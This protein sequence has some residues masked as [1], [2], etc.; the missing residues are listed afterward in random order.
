M[1]KKKKQ[2]KTTKVTPMNCLLILYIYTFDRVWARKFSWVNGVL[3]ASTHKTEISSQKSV[4]RI[5]VVEN[6]ID[7]HPISL[8]LKISTKLLNNQFQLE[9]PFLK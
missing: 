3:L 6:S 1:P 9:V 4:L 2:K 5:T 7:Q 8:F